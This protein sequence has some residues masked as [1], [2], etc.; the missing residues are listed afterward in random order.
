[1]STTEHDLTVASDNLSLKTFKFT[2]WIVG[3]FIVVA[4]YIT[5]STEK[6]GQHAHVEPAGEHAPADSG[7]HH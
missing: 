7:K 3:G 4:A 6:T 2:M 1:M 5:L